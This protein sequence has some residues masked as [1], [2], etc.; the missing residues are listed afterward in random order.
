VHA[1]LQRFGN[2][3]VIAVVVVS[4]NVDCCTLLAAATASA[5]VV[6]PIALAVVDAA[7]ATA[8]SGDAF[9]ERFVR[10]C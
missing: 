9:N 3:A 2:A 7:S 5:T 6:T 10:Q 1:Y 8:T 4:S